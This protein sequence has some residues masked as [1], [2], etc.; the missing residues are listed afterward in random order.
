MDTPISP[1]P[2][3]DLPPRQPE[4]LRYAVPVATTETLPGVTDVVG[5]VVGVATRP[6]DQ[7][8]DPDMLWINTRARQDALGAMAL[9]AE[10]A[11]ADAVVGVR[12]DSG[13]ISE[14]VAEI[15]AYGTA[16]RLSSTNRA[17]DTDW[18]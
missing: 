16:V 1:R 17:A 12:F 3:P 15:T 13:R 9:Q 6:R 8:H 5:I 10:Q 4:F 7:A 11:G 18:V 2:Q 14:S